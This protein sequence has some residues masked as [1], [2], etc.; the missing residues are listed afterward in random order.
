MKNIQKIFILILAFCQSINADTLFEKAK[1]GKIKSVKHLVLE[2]QQK[3]SSVVQGDTPLLAAVKNYKQ[4]SVLAAKDS[5]EELEKDLVNYDQVILFL[6]SQGASMSDQDKNGRTVFHYAVASG[7]EHLLKLLLDNINRQSERAFN[8][9]DYGGYTPIHFAAMLANLEM[10]EILCNAGAKV[11]LPTT[12]EAKKPIDMV[13]RANQTASAP[14]I[15]S[16]KSRLL[17]AERAPIAPQPIK[18]HSS[19]RPIII[20]STSRPS[21]P[22]RKDVTEKETMQPMAVEKTLINQELLQAQLLNAL[23][24]GYLDEVKR[25]VAQGA[26]LSM[27]SPEG[28]T[29]LMVVIKFYEPVKQHKEII[30]Y[31]IANQADLLERDSEGKTALHYALEDENLFLI[32]TILN[33]IKDFPNKDKIIGAQDNQGNTPLHYAA[34]VTNVPIAQELLIHNASINAQNKEKRQIPLDVIGS[35]KSVIYKNRSNTKLASDKALM[36]EL[37]SKHGAALPKPKN[38][39]TPA[40]ASMQLPHKKLTPSSAQNSKEIPEEWDLSRVG[41]TRSHSIAQP[42]ITQPAAQK[43]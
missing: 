26:S 4:P 25:L 18:R 6:L 41:R 5:K 3:I 13:G 22:E 37:L 35:E 21:S 10:I 23:A 42:I 1:E 36:R 31:L 33:A 9:A 28:L 24:D 30:E 17:R 14:T 34:M 19:V 15:A 43:D 2:K 39:H 11:G 20:A 38:K 12:I 29:P 27:P 40:A 16:I 32:K 7:N 8:I